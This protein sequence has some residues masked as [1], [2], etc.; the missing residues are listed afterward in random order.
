MLG[1]I[2]HLKNFRCRVSGVGGHAASFAENRDAMLGHAASRGDRDPRAAN[3][4]KGTGRVNLEQL[5]GPAST[6]FGWR[7]LRTLGC[8]AGSGMDRRG[9]RTSFPL[10]A[11]LG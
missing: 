11:N 3:F 10:R 6:S 9:R 2:D 4:V 5:P 8:T 1:E 7:G